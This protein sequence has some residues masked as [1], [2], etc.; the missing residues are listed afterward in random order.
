MLIQCLAA[1]YMKVAWS[2]W[3]KRSLWLEK[4]MKKINNMHMKKQPHLA[5]TVEQ[6]TCK[7]DGA[8]GK[9]LICSQWTA[10]ENTLCVSLLYSK[11]H[12]FDFF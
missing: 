10:A 7:T 8:S 5:L 12:T 11:M 2:Q 9:Q 3:L 6:S 4:H 1:W